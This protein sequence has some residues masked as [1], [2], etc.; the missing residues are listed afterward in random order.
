M[1]QFAKLS[2]RWL[3]VILF[4][5]VPQSSLVFAAENGVADPPP[6]FAWAKEPRPLTDIAFTDEQGTPLT[7]EDFRGKWVVLNMWATFCIPCLQE[8]PSLNNLQAKLGGAEFEVVALNEDFGKIERKVELATQYYADN[9]LENLKVYVDYNA[10]DKKSYFK[11]QIGGMPTT[12][13][14]DPDGQE[15]GRHCG[16]ADWDGDEALDILRSAMVGTRVAAA[17]DARQLCPDLD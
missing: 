6:A 10:L 14:I 7:L 9:Q 17:A 15:L 16:A 1:Y 5:A 13:L 2:R 3:V 12:I 8:M 4:A 11:L